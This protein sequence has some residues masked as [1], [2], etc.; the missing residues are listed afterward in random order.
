MKLIKFL[1][2]IAR[3]IIALKVLVSDRKNFDDYSYFPE[4]S[5]KRKTKFRIFCEQLCHVVKYSYCNNFYFLLGFDIKDFR[6]QIEYVDNNTFMRQ[7]DIQ[8][9]KNN[10]SLISVLRDKSI[11]DI[12]ANKY[13]I[14]TPKILSLVDE[15]RNVYDYESE[16]QISF[17]EYLKKSDFDV[18]LKVI[19]GECADGV[20]HIICNKEY[21]MYQDNKYSIE[22]FIDMLPKG[23]KLILQEKMTEQHP[24]INLIYSKAINTIRLI[25]VI[26]PITKKPTVFSAVL[27]VGVGNSEVDNWATGGLAIGID[28]ESGQLRKYGYYKPGYG[29]K[30]DE[31]PDTHVSFEG[32]TVPYMKEALD[33]AC[34]FHSILSS[35]HSIGWDIAIT[36]NGPCF[37][38]GNE[39]WEI[40]ALQTCN[41]GLQSEFEKLFY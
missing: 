1:K 16:S 29:T 20:F 12:V 41:Y 11:F 31:H 8:N 22:D 9:H 24:A 10:N 34:R 37:I 39:N 17:V 23:S 33:E 35:V 2:R 4:Y 5:S 6:N 13:K 15:H 32:Y 19:D 38:E 27:R 40:P 26:S 18:F 21:V 7:R 36:E 28:T 14:C 25:T 30:T 3:T